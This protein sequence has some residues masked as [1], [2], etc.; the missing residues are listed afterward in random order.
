M[1]CGGPVASTR[2]VQRFLAMQAPSERLATALLAPLLEPAGLVYREDTG[3]TLGEA[4]GAAPGAARLLVAVVVD[5]RPGSLVCVPAGAGAPQA[6]EDIPWERA[7]AVVADRVADATR[8]RDRLARVGAARPASI[9]SLRGILRGLVRLPRGADLE[10]ICAALGV[11]WLDTG[12]AAGT[13]VAMAACLAEAGLPG[14]IERSGGAGEEPL[15]AMPGPVREA[16]AVLPEAPGVYRFY[17]DAGE[18]LY[19]GKAKNLRRRV[20]AHFT[21]RRPGAR[22]GWSPDQVHRIEHDPLNSELEALLEEARQIGE[23]SPSGNIQFEVHERNHAAPACG[24]SGCWALLLPAPAGHGV[25]AV[26]VRDG[27]YMG[28]IRIGP[29][30]GGLANARRLLR[31]AVRGPGPAHRGAGRDRDTRILDSWLAR[32]GEGVSRLELDGFSSPTE[33]ARALQDA[34]RRLAGE[35]GPVWFRRG[36]GSEVSAGPESGRPRRGE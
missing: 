3:W 31:R 25:T 14:R 4:P 23:R 18:L 15:D 16:I 10:T 28:R 30:G 26:V 1:R 22:G 5:R 21:R 9:V 35:G 8:L 13:A 27:V 36:G 17:D 7:T 6:A 32:H 11:R 29:R 20:M 34:A 12:D 24:A 2:L 19:V 33:A